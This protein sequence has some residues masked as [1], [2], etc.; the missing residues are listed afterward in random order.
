MADQDRSA[1]RG[2]DLASTGR[3]GAGNV[4]RSES[5]NGTRVSRAEDGDERGREIFD[6]RERV[7]HAGRGG[8]GNVRSPSRDAS[9][10]AE[11]RAYEDAIIRKRRLE[12]EAQ[13]VSAGRGGTGNISRDP[14]RSRSRVRDSHPPTYE[15]GVGRGGAGNIDEAKHY[16]HLGQGELETIDDDER[17]EALRH[18]KIHE[19]NHKGPHTH[20]GSLL[21]STGRGGGGNITSDVTDQP[22]STDVAPPVPGIVNHP[23]RGGAGN[24][25]AAV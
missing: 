9:K 20:L 6:A 5:A 15:T 21:H 4:V 2:R 14:S 11:E 22:N 10:L 8:Q 23:G 25:E 19:R 13:P 3:G 7:T 24:I 16:R 18:E 1:S 12:R 17:I